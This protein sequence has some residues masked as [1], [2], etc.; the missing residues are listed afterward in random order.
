MI[1]INKMNCQSAVI[2]FDRSGIKELMLLHRARDGARKAHNSPF[3][4]C[5]MNKINKAE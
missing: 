5:F 2:F 4:L 1:V 3:P